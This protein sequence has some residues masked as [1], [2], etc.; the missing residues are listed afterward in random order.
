MWHKGRCSSRRAALCY[1][2]CA[3]VSKGARNSPAPPHA[4]NTIH[5]A[6]KLL[7]SPQQKKWRSTTH[8]V[9]R[10][11]LAPALTSSGPCEPCNT[12]STPPP[13]HP[14]SATL[15][16]SVASTLAPALT[17][18]WATSSRPAWTAT[19]RGVAPSRLS[20]LRQERRPA[21]DS[22]SFTTAAP[23]RCWGWEV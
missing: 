12:H 13:P 16:L 7:C 21:S 22:R 14:P 18:S 15:T 20:A 9:G 4:F 2:W 5:P 19:C 17:S 3:A 23:L 1:L 11:I 6:T 8:P 10:S